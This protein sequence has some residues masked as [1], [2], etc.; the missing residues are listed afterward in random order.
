MLENIKSSFVSATVITVIIAIL[1]IIFGNTGTGIFS[2]TMVFVLG[3]LFG[4]PLATVGRF[5]GSLF[6]GAHEAFEYIGLIGGALVG[7]SFAILLFSDKQETSFMYNCVHDHGGTKSQ[8]ECVYS[9]VTDKYE[10]DELLSL[11]RNPTEDYQ[12]YYMNSYKECG[13]EKNSD[14]NTPVKIN[15]ASMNQ[16]IDDAEPTDSSGGNDNIKILDGD[17]DIT[18]D[19]VHLL[20]GGDKESCKLIMDSLG[21]VQETD[22]ISLTNSKNIKIL[23]TKMKK[24]C[25]T[26]NE[27]YEYLKQS[28]SN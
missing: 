17:E 11:L 24:T 14:V 21:Q 28:L 6:K 4:A 26:E 27:I 5:I 8:C 7:I 12:N 23:C 22:C 15:Q 16:K 9:K 19:I 20:I 2:N 3:T 25:K 13:G 18:S 10:D 1:L